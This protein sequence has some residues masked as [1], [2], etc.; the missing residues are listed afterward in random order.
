MNFLKTLIGLKFSLLTDLM[1]IAV[2]AYLMVI[3]VKIKP[4]WKQWTLALSIFCLYG[5]GLKILNIPEE[6]IHLLEYGFLSF[7]VFKMYLIDRLSI[8]LYWQTFLTVSFIGTLDE[9]I[10][11][12]IPSR[13]GDI[14]DIILNIVSGLLGLILTAVF[15]Q[16][17]AKNLPN[18]PPL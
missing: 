17:T 13:V 15:Y 3:L 9:I 12:F 6:R 11:Y 10:Q 2:I 14:R 7:L 1:L 18:S 5:Y 4:T 16:K 8:L